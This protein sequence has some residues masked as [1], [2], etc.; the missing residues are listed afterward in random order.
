MRLMG[1]VFDV[2]EAAQSERRILF[3]LADID[4]L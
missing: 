2:E 1:S 4:D 3:T